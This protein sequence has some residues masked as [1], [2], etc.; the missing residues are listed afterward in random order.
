MKETM[1]PHSTFQHFPYKLFIRVQRENRTV[2][3]CLRLQDRFIRTLFMNAEA[4][5]SRATT[6]YLVDQAHVLDTRM[7]LYEA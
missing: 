5:K 2:P 7:R 6:D 3:S 4:G 1:Q